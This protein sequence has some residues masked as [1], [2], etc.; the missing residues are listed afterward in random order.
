[1]ST[2]AP[3]YSPFYVKAWTLLSIALG[4]FFLALFIFGDDLLHAGGITWNLLRWLAR[5][6]I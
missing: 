6:F 5:P 4:L 2:P 3:A 1:M